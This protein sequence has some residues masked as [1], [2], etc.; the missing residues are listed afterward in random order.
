MPCSQYIGLRCH[1]I[2][3]LRP[4]IPKEHLLLIGLE[5]YMFN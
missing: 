5:Y 4:K 3:L 2:N 1:F